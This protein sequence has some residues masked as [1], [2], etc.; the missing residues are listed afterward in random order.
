[1]SIAAKNYMNKSYIRTQSEYYYTKFKFYRNKLN[2]LL[3]ISKKSY[4]N[5]YFS[6]NCKNI[7]GTWKGIRQ[8]I[9]LKQKN[10]I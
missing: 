4:Y 6:E 7:K 1:M 8:L 10:F 5:N 9:I 2:H 3:A